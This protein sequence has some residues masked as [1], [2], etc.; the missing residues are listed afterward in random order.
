MKDSFF[1]IGVIRV[2]QTVGRGRSLHLRLDVTVNLFFVIPSGKKKLVHGEAGR[3]MSRLLVSLSPPFCVRL[4]IRCI[5]QCFLSY[6]ITFTSNQSEISF[7][8]SKSAP[9]TSHSQPISD[10]DLVCFHQ[11][12]FNSRHIKKNLTI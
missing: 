6:Q 8:Y 5:Q 7:S 12:F 2:I 3:A 10:W 11:F 1:V 4:C 9:V